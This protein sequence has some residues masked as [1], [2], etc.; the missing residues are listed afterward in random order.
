MAETDVND[1]SQ[2]QSPED[3]ARAVAELKKETEGLRKA[4]GAE[5]TK[6]QTGDIKL[7]EVAGKLDGLS[8]SQ[9][10]KPTGPPQYTRPQLT[11]FV[12]N[13]QLSQA[14]ADR[15]YE[16]QVEGRI[17]SNVNKVVDQ[18]FASAAMENTKAGIKDIIA[19]YRKA[20]PALEDTDTPER[21]RAEAEYASLIQLG[22]PQSDETEAAALR[23][24][25]GPVDKIVKGKQSLETHQETGSDAD[26]DSEGSTSDG[27]PKGLPR[28]F[29]EHY[30]AQIANG[31][32][33][34]WDDKTLK[35]EI[36]SFKTKQD[37]K[38][39]KAA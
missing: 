24:A 8:V 4:L 13:G 32:Y 6:R 12:D 35:V 19:D 37:Q 7:A 5:R 25:F 10:S 27:V 39:R 30:T 9:S 21:R 33:T 38:K 20:I 11:Q 3:A 28:Y 14:D 16:N 15:I 1:Q 34:G 18:K 36:D 29:I 23:S 2:G 26:Q 22:L 17:L 31:R